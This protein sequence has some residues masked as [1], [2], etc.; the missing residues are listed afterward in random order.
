MSSD[1]TTSSSSASKAA[2]KM[3]HILDSPRRV[4]IKKAS[5]RRRKN[6]TSSSDSNQSNKVGK[7]HHLMDGESHVN[8]DYQPYLENEDFFK[9]RQSHS[10]S[11]S[12]MDHSV[13]STNVMSWLHD[14]APQDIIPKVLSY[15][16]PQ[17]H[18][19]LSRLNKSWNKICLSEGVFRTLSE[20]Y[21][22]W[23]EGKDHFMTV[24]DNEEQNCESMEVDDDTCDYPNHCESKL[25]FWRIFYTNNP[26]VPL[27]YPT[28]D[29]AI[30]ALGSYS[31]NHRAH[32][33]DKS[34]RVLLAPG[35]HVVDNSIKVHLHGESIFTVETLHQPRG[36]SSSSKG[37]NYIS[38]NSTMFSKSYIT[39]G[40]G[41]GIAP[42]SPPRRER[43]H[44]RGSFRNIFACRSDAG[45]SDS[46]TEM[47]D[48]EAPV[49]SSSSALSN[50]SSFVSKLFDKAV[51]VIKTKVENSPVFHISQ[52][53]I[54]LSN[55]TMAHNCPGTD[56][57]NG[58]TVVQVQP[59][60]LNN[61]PVRPRPGDKIPSAIIE[62]STLTSVSGRGIVAIDG[63]HATIRKCLITNCAATGIYVGGAGSAALI[64][65]SDIIHNG[66]G[67]EQSRRGIARGHSGVYL[68]QGIATLS[69]CNVSNNSL[70]G[71]SAVSQTNA[72]L[73]VQDTDLV[74]NGTIQLEMPPAGSLSRQRSISVNNVISAD[75][76]GRSRSGHADVNEP[77]GD[78]VLN[79]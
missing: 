15:L 50:S 28:I 35:I 14:E 11:R 54:K 42:I 49:S 47:D 71:I 32:E 51:V 41:R 3:F 2:Q 30:S 76:E 20:D 4:L 66:N 60:L 78:M 9:I 64:E 45:A 17:K 31:R 62:D 55:I 58:N 22:K 39:R 16:G 18:Q 8:N 46:N 37:N 63:G 52:G 33:F 67:N 48:A 59:L 53:S 27:D 34:V 36:S 74:G 7:L 24:M 61:R 10:E 73:T 5:N 13:L 68:E 65:D 23:E 12:L 29:H 40:N 70:T 6:S 43:S 69:N 79:F 1:S 77:N 72:T 56:I 38:F 44:H 57:W 25:M 26:I 75:G 21:G 19:V